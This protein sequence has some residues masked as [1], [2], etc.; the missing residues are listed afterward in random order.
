MPRVCDR[1][2]LGRLGNTF[3][4]FPYD[5]FVIVVRAFA[6]VGI[7]SLWQGGGKIPGN[8]YVIVGLDRSIVPRCQSSTVSDWSLLVEIAAKKN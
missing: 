1:S 7:P 3:P 5:G 2:T 4:L 6:I 8:T